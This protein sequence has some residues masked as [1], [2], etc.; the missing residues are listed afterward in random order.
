MITVHRKKIVTLLFFVTCLPAHSLPKV[1]FFKKLIGQPPFFPNALRDTI[2]AKNRITENFHTVQKNKLYRSAQ[3]SPQTL[4]KYIQ[5]HKIKTVVNLR[6]MNPTETWWQQEQ[7]VC[8]DSNV[9]FFNIA[10]SAQTMTSKEN[11]IT[12]LDIYRTAPKPILIHCYSGADRTG[13]AA[14]LWC[15]EIQKQRRKHAKKQLSP[16]YGHFKSK[17]PAKDFLIDIWRG[18]AWLE[19]KYDSA[20]YPQF[21]QTK[22]S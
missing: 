2:N 12:L 8:Q 5:H 7:E 10:M 15:L 11:L 6:G 20:Q 19:H 22:K 18:R 17:Y 4:R 14:A 9:Q 21:M 16:W 1:T 13:E 3:L